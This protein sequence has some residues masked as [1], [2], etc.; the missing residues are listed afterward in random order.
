MLSLIHMFGPCLPVA[1]GAIGNVL[2]MV[3]SVS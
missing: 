1:S 3:N 2:S